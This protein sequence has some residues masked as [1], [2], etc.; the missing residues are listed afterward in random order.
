MTPRPRAHCPECDSLT[1]NHV[2]KEEK[3]KC[4]QCGWAGSEPVMRLQESWE[5]SR[6]ESHH[7]LKQLYD[8]HREHPE[9]TRKDL[10][11][12]GMVGQGTVDRY[13]NRFVAGKVHVIRPWG[14]VI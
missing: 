3:W 13:W 9:Y 2:V 10:R 4:H 1:I 11:K 14:D 12:Y 8:L 7:W 5:I 6:G